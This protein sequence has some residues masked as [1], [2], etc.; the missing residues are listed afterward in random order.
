M[1]WDEMAAKAVLEFLRDRRVG[2]MVM[3]RAPEEG[4]ADC[5]GEE[6][7]PGPP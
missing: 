5:E 6:S 4:G 3:A 1:L 2:G 7:E